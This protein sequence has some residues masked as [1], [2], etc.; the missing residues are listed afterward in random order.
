MSDRRKSKF[1]TLKNTKLNVILVTPDN[2]NKY[3]KE[4]LHEGYQY[5]SET[6]KADYLRTYFMHFIGG[7]YSDIK[8]TKESWLPYVKLLES[9][10]NLWCIGY[11]EVSNGVPQIGDDIELTNK[12]RN[13]YEKLIGN[14][15]YIFKPNTLLTK[16]WYSTM[17]K[18]MDSKLENLKKYPAR[19]T[20]DVYSEEYPYPLRWTELLGE[21][22][23]QTIYKYL[24]HINN[25]L[26]PPD[27]FNYR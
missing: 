8:E 21:I 13:D 12:L 3:I 17:M 1:D 2:L 4:P 25:S 9:D 22:F 24:D 14:G 27:F 5:L 16:E 26:P 6:H 15:A 18:V 11:K 23:H 19:N 10:P 7:G 20:E